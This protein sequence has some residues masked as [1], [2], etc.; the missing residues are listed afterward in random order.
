MAGVSEGERDAGRDVDDSHEDQDDRVEQIARDMRQ[1][2]GLGGR[3]LG[4]EGTTGGTTVGRDLQEELESSAHGEMT[5]S[6]PYDSG[7]AG[8]TARGEGLGQ[9]LD[10]EDE[11]AE[12][13]E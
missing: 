1:G 8:R 3:T 11:P 6:H 5:A 4:E 12:R 9:A 10:D 13:G 2:V 7:M